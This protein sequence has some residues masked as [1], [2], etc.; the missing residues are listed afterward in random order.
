MKRL[1]AP[2]RSQYTEEQ[3][4][5]KKENATPKECIFCHHAR[6][7]TEKQKKEDYILLRTNNCYI[8]LNQYP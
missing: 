5:T 4:A 8:L 3:T 6:L 2:W 1:Y 7:T